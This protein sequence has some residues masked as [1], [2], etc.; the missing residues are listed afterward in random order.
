MRVGGDLR[1]GTVVDGDYSATDV[2][3]ERFAVITATITTIVRRTTTIVVRGTTVLVHQTTTIFQQFRL[4]TTTSR[5]VKAP[6][7]PRPKRRRRR[8]FIATAFTLLV[9]AAVAGG[10]LLFKK[11]GPLMFGYDYVA[12]SPN[13]RFL[14]SSAGTIKSGTEEIYV[15]DMA[16][17]RVM[18]TI[19]IPR[20][21]L[22][23][24]AVSPDSKTIAVAHISDVISLWNVAAGRVV[25]TLTAPD[26]YG[27]GCLAFS[28]DSETLAACG[29]TKVY[30]WSIPKHT[31]KATLSLPRE[32]YSATP[33]SAAFSPD[34][35]TLAVSQE[36][37]D[38]KYKPSD[39][40][41]KL[42]QPG[43]EFWNV[44]TL[45]MT[46]SLPAART[47]WT[48]ISYSHDGR[49]LAT[50][51]TDG[52]TTLWHLTATPPRGDPLSSSASCSS[53]SSP[54]LGSPGDTA[55]FSPDDTV[56]ATAGGY[57]ALL[58]N[59]KGVQIGALRDPNSRGV[60][61]LGFT[62]DSKMLVTADGNGRIYLWDIATRH[63]VTTLTNPDS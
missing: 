63:L 30:L 51:Y 58:L 38:E 17:K 28:P 5:L 29:S 13:G 55:V 10:I 57:Y 62:S 32:Q 15:W 9:A 8:A 52:G 34:G 3:W 43:V 59:P 41:L 40:S 46:G 24:I 11:P 12:I 2:C 14:V 53:G 23:G 44:R 60:A 50:C 16:A 47:D 21:D 36:I 48:R 19:S 4:H 7:P 42:D 49:M 6:P 35:K 26:P 45:K 39:S 22:Y 61:D 31:I 20:N 37:T 56:L 1:H 18:A 54:L 25:A 27:A 33:F